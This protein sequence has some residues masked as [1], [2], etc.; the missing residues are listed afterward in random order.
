MRNSDLLFLSKALTAKKK[1]K[2]P[3]DRDQFTL[4][5]GQHRLRG[6]VK[7]DITADVGEDT[8]ADRSFGVPTDD[9]LDLAA[10]LC[11]ALRPHL[12]KSSAV[13]TEITRA[14]LE[15]RA[16][17]GTSY[18]LDGKAKRVSR[19]EVRRLAVALAEKDSKLELSKSIKVSRP[20]AGQIRIVDADV[21]VA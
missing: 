21:S 4:T 9:I 19:A 3:V 20:Y 14:K 15:D 13:V 18:V 10:H 6:T 1:G 17:R 12:Y 7:Y 2:S 16:V 5:P 11:G 8:E